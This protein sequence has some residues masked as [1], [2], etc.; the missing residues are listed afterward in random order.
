MFPFPIFSLVSWATWIAKGQVCIQRTARTKQASAW[1][2]S[3]FGILQPLNI[4]S[5]T[6]LLFKSLLNS[7]N[8]NFHPH[9]HSS[10][11]EPAHN[12]GKTGSHSRQCKFP[13]HQ[14]LIFF[15]LMSSHSSSVTQ[16][17]R[18]IP[19]FP[20]STDWLAHLCRCSCLCTLSKVRGPSVITRLDRAPKFKW[21][22]AKPCSEEWTLERARVAIRLDSRPSQ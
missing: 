3:E 14:R 1:I 10:F 11:D 13:G 21:Y 20:S 15:L 9:P 7:P 16:P 18:H 17:G 2:Q 8:I 6:R 4:L 5:T 22:M 12:I 19:A